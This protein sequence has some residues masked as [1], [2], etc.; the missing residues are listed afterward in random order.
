MTLLSIFI[1]APSSDLRRVEDVAWALRR[2]ATITEPWHEK[3]RQRLDAGLTDLDLTPAEA[4]LAANDCRDGIFEASVILWLSGPSM[5][6]AWEASLAYALGKPVIASGL[7]HCIYGSRCD[8]ILPDDA[9]AIAW[10]ADYAV[11]L[12]NVSRSIAKG[13]LRVET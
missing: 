11:R 5:G 4:L 10:L 8:A 1:A 2:F 9:H 12:G 7:P 3:M 13:T 6:A